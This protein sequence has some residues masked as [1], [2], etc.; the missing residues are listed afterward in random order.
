MLAIASGA[1]IIGFQI[2]LTSKAK[3][4]SET[5]SV[6]IR[7]YNII[8]DCIDEIK[9]ALEGLLTPETKEEIV[10]SIEVRKVFKV[11][12]SGNIAGC[13]I[14]SGKIT[15]NDK[16]RLLRK[17]LPVFTGG[18]QSLKRNKDDVR[19]VDNGYE[20]GIMLDGW[21]DIQSGDII[22][23]FKIIEVKRTFH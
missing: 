14:Q 11:S 6:D 23:A 20:C 12:K 16:V 10:A 17:G 18:I 22:E 13:Y 3:K 21:N 4:L 19:E 2:G 7:T 1:I 5:E 9:L 15:R 8:Y